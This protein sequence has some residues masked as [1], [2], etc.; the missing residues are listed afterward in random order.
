MNIQI[1]KIELGYTDSIKISI[2]NHP[3]KFIVVN[4]IGGEINYKLSKQEV[5]KE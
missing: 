2:I 1:K 3:E 5:M 4:G